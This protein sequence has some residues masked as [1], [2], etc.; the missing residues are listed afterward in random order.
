MNILYCYIILLNP[1]F[2]R[3][4]RLKINPKEIDPYKINAVALRNRL[5]C[6]GC[7]SR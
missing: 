5:T 6:R 3:A 4:L 1:S 2:F 7:P